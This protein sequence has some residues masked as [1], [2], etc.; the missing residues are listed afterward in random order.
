MGKLTVLQAIE[1][2]P[3]K[4]YLSLREVKKDLKLFTKVIAA[5]KIKLVPDSLDNVTLD[6]LKKSRINSPKNVRVVTPKAPPPKVKPKTGTRDQPS[7]GENQAPVAPLPKVKSPDKDATVK[8][9]E[10]MAPTFVGPT[11]DIS[12]KQVIPD[13]INIDTADKNELTKAN[14]SLDKLY[15]QRELIA[16]IVN[17][18]QSGFANIGDDSSDNIAKAL[19]AAKAIENTIKA[20]I[21]AVRTSL[22]GATKE[23]LPESFVKLIS[24]V[25]A[26][27]KN[28][29]NTST[30][31]KVEVSYSC[32]SNDSGAF[33]LS[34]FLIFHNIETP[35]GVTPLYVVALSLLGQNY[36]INAKLQ[37]VPAVGKFS[38]G[39]KLPNT[40]QIARIAKRY[41]DE[42]FA[43]DDNMAAVNTVPVPPHLEG[44]DIQNMENVDS[45][46]FTDDGIEVNF[47]ANINNDAKCADA[48]NKLFII[49]TNSL[50][51]IG[52]TKIKIRITRGQDDGHWFALFQFSKLDKFS[53]RTLHRDEVDYLSKLFTQEDIKKIRF[54]LSSVKQSAKKAA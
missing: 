35:N 39:I 11:T 30:K 14:E 6:D 47:K 33:Q 2:L 28:R 23:M 52:E 32:G 50:A 3:L 34:A 45:V 51:Y 42:Q 46:T 10:D 15:R 13:S 54:V 31:H 12:N 41:I 21:A 36:Y 5:N 38:I 40:D 9:F 48:A 16:N 37:R 7:K 24:S 4:Q 8:I 19:K 27:V 29:I 44:I 1:R 17:S 43:F 20:Q 26:N 18:L 53:G 22:S 25:A 49:F